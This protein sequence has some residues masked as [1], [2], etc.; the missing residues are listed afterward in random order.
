MPDVTINSSKDEVSIKEFLINAKKYFR[1]LLYQWKIILLL[2][3]IGAVAG[4]YYANKQKNLYTASVVFV[5][6]D[7]NDGGRSSALNGLA[8]QMGV[9]G[10][11]GSDGGGI[12]SKD[13]LMWLFKSRMIVEKTLLNTMLIDGKPVS[14]IE[15]YLEFSN[16]R[17]S[18]DAN[19]ETKQIIFPPLADR[20]KFSIAQIRLLENIYLRMVNNNITVGIKDKK[21]G[22]NNLEVTS[23]DELFSKYF[24][25]SLIREVSDFY[26]ETKSK[27]ARINMEALKKQSDSIRAELNGSLTSDAVLNDNIF[28]LNAA[29]N[30]VK[31]LPSAKN[32]IDLQ[33]N[34]TMLMQ[35]ITSLESAKSDLRKATPLIQVIEA[36]ILPLRVQVVDKTGYVIKFMLLS[37]FL[38]V[39]FL[40]GIKWWK[41]NI[42]SL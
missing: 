38:S 31:K 30:N 22:I 15:R 20:S 23:Q 26:I 29:L 21:P 5:M 16:M 10:F 33:A 36:P 34:T 11:S 39:I 35:L 3:V 25:E 19:P 9:L 1:Y 42:G 12:F 18:M 14:F 7:A 17:K 2:A 40:F 24:A 27:K 37:V 28:N 41:E 4:Y 13:N 8:G 32:K 6:E